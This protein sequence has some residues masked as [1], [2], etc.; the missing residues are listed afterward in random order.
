MR[1]FLLTSI[2]LSTAVEG[3]AVYTDVT[4]A[5][6]RE[7]RLETL[8]SNL[9]GIVYRCRNE[10]DWP[11]V[12]VAGDAQSLVGYSADQL[13]DGDVVWSDDVLVD[14]E[15]ERLWAEVQSAVDARKPFRVSY[16][17]ETADGEVRRMWEQGRG[18]FDEDGDLEA[19][20]GFIT[21]VTSHHRLTQAFSELTA[22][23]EDP[24]VE[25][26]RRVERAVDVVEAVS[27]D[28][29]FEL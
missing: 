3:Y 11:M 1:D 23:L 9:P 14:G 24:A 22:T 29:L 10:P 13:E 2:P 17:V 12:F 20:E 27:L 16:D 25:P 6:E 26:S 4:E 21:D 5:R 28:P 7:R 18:V 8:V 15:N 19:L